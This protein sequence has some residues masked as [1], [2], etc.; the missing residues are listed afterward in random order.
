MLNLS[1]ETNS[2]TAIMN[3][4]HHHS[5]YHHLG[6][7][8]NLL[9]IKLSWCLL[10][11]HFKQLD[12]F[13]QQHCTTPVQLWSLSQISQSLYLDEGTEKHF[14]YCFWILNLPVL[15]ESY[16]PRCNSVISIQS[17]VWKQHVW[18]SLWRQWTI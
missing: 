5:L 9:I 7:C 1:G 10:N 16:F 11:A 15:G 13:Q 18:V 4:S 3:G 8:L 12:Q 2:N 6:W 14:C 17:C